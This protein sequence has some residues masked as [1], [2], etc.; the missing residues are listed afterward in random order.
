M[1]KLQKIRILIQACE[2]EIKRSDKKWYADMAKI[3]AYE[4]ILKIM[5][6][7]DE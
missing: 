5:K 6:G 7:E 4:E 2:A 3:A 1:D